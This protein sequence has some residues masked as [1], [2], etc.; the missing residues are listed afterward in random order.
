[1]SRAENTPTISVSITRKAIMYSFT[2]CSTECQEPTQ[3]RVSRVLSSTNQSEM[4]STP[5]W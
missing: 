2:R 5:R 3:T 4:P 1:M